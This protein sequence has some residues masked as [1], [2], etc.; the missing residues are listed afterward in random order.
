M[1]D[2]VGII[3]RF[4]IPFSHRHFKIINAWQTAVECVYGLCPLY[5]VYFYSTTHMLIKTNTFSVLRN[6]GL[7]VLNLVTVIIILGGCKQAT[8]DKSKSNESKTIDSYLE[9][10][11]QRQ[12]IP[13]LTV[14]ATRN[15]SV[16]YVGAFGVRNEVTKEPLKPTNIFHWASVSKTFVA[17]AIMQLVEKGKINLDEKLITYLPY[18]KQHGEDYKKITIRQ[19]LNHTSGIGDVEDYEW[20]KPQYDEAAP[21]RYVESLTNDKM[22]FAPG[23]DMAYSNTA[24]EILGVVISQVSGM[25]FETYIKENIFIPLEMNH[26]SFIYPEIPDSL[27]V[28]G[29]LWANKPIVS[30]VYP[31]NR[32]H[33]P[34]STLNS[35]VVEMT[36]YTMANLNHGKYKDVRI[37]ADSSYKI[38]W[39]NSVNLKDKSAVG[40]SWFLEEYRGLKTVRHGGGDTGFRSFIWLIPEKN[41]SV[42]LASNY[43]LTQSGDITRAVIDILLGEK[44]PIIKRR[45]GFS[46]AEILASQ[47]LEKAKAFYK[48]TNEDSS[49]RKYYFWDEK[50]NALTNPGYELLDRKLPD[51]AIELFKFNLELNPNSAMAYGNLGVAY[52]QIGNKEDAKFNLTKAIK[53]DPK[54]E[55]FKEEL[56]KLLRSK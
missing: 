14:A 41:I 19:M 20:D 2:A 42:V 55:G 49:Q 12:Q 27:R 54:N 45:V 22:L 4:V 39:T 30:D 44:P 24:F 50:E 17:M 6:A 15:D 37:L 1:F 38:L 33:A 34:S 35:N 11:V 25:P 36:H 8:T 21:K 46:F 40:V 31:Y 16:V 43:E 56:K 3:N 52:S 48:K 26:T 13:G 7:L 5:L 47:G 53:L 28:S 23:T 51:E 9:E 32:I 18:F 10:L 29:H